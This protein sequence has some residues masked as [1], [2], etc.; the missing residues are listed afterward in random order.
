[1]TKD[2]DPGF[3]RG[4][5]GVDNTG[6]TTPSPWT[7]VQRNLMSQPDGQDELPCV[8]WDPLSRKGLLWVTSGTEGKEEPS[9]PGG[10]AACTRAHGGSSR[11][12]RSRS[13]RLS[14]VSCWGLALPEDEKGVL[15]SVLMG[16]GLCVS[17]RCCHSGGEGAGRSSLILR[18]QPCDDLR[19]RVSRHGVK[20]WI[21]VPRGSNHHNRW[22]FRDNLWELLLSGHILDTPDVSWLR[23]SWILCPCVCHDLSWTLSSG[24]PAPGMQEFV[25]SLRKSHNILLLMRGFKEKFQ[26]MWKDCRQNSL[27]WVSDPSLYQKSSSSDGQKVRDRWE[28]PLLRGQQVFV[29]LPHRPGALC[30]HLE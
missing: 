16:L 20:K 17:P 9:L 10:A 11:S 21:R 24:Q 25:P 12:I 2:G 5:V 27:R 28:V 18:P 22:G 3:V 6:P 23:Q 1:M 13:H 15:L 4:Q 14:L 30:Q 7:S 26:R 29:S 8:L 19:V